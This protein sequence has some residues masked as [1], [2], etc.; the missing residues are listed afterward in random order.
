MKR[1]FDSYLTNNH[2]VYD[3]HENYY[4]SSTADNLLTRVD[5]EYLEEELQSRLKQKFDVSNLLL[6]NKEFMDYVYG[7][8]MAVT[9]ECNIFVQHY[10]L[11]PRKLSIHHLLES[12]GKETVVVPADANSDKIVEII[13]Q[14]F[15]KNPHSEEQTYIVVTAGTADKLRGIFS[16]LQ[17]LYHGFTHE[18]ELL[19][20]SK[21]IVVA[22]FRRQIRFAFCTCKDFQLSSVLEFKDLI[23]TCARI[24]VKKPSKATVHASINLAVDTALFNQ[25]RNLAKVFP[26]GNQSF[27]SNE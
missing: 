10:E 6:F 7:M 18:E 25:S 23:R 26:S 13:R 1:S 12:L 14:I 2:P 22:S 20:N 27:Q 8:Y 5:R 9:Y 4:L 24:R 11:L 16:V 17:R 15:K 21:K 19:L 3:P